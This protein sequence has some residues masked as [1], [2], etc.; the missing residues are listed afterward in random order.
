MNRNN[1]KVIR[2]FLL[3]VVSA[4]S[5]AASTAMAQNDSAPDGVPVNT[6]IATVP[7]GNFPYDLVV[8]PD[9]NFVYVANYLDNTVSVI[10]AQT[11]KVQTTLPAGGTPDALAISADGSKL[12]VANAN[13]A[14]VTVIDLANGNSTQTITGL[15]PLPVAFAL[16]PDGKQ[17]WVSDGQ[18]VGNI[19]VI[20][21]ASNQVLAPI[22]MPEVI[23]SFAFTPDGLKAYVIG[24]VGT[25]TILVVDTT[26]HQVTSTI[27]NGEGRDSLVMSPTGKT[28]YVVGRKKPGG[29]VMIIDTTLNQVIKNITLGGISKPGDQAAILPD[30]AY[31][32]VPRLNSARVDLID[33]Q[34]QTR[35][36]GGFT[37]APFPSV[38]AIA[39]DG[40]RAYV[41]CQ[42][43]KVTVV[44]ITE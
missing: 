2:D 1:P 32:Y 34:T 12:Y 6:V 36:G 9:G 40:K 22:A 16:T 17:L 8:S 5:L 39:P 25:A 35:V 7:V 24:H 3:F 37:T 15:A 44:R 19:D 10:N 27:Q 26:S 42:L 11:N 21:T 14:T 23:G 29:H 13:V 28:V 43:N 18:K 38:I 4:I 41:A 33:T 30:G 31:L 20:D